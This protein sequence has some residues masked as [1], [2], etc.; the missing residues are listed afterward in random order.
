MRAG[1]GRPQLCHPAPPAPVPSPD[2]VG[3]W[4][5]YSTSVCLS[6]QKVLERGRALG[7]ELGRA[8]PWGGWTQPRSS[9]IFP[10]APVLEPACRLGSL[11]VL[12]AQGLRYLDP[13][14]V[15]VLG[16]RADG[17][18]AT[19]PSGQL[20]HRVHEARVVPHAVDEPRENAQDTGRRRGQRTPHASDSPAHVHLQGR[21]G[22][23]R[24]NPGGHSEHHGVGE[25]GGLREILQVETGGEADWPRGPALARC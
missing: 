7:L 4:M 9:W 20:C 24:H 12:T 2:P 13:A 8:G 22:A 5:S 23:G 18:L 21:L 19:G 14:V 17:Q 16:L 1:S 15:A 25:D 6:L 3:E 11:E 10:A